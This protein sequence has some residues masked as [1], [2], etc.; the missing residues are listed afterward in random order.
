MTLINQSLEQRKLDEL[1]F[2]EKAKDAAGLFLNFCEL[3]SVSPDYPYLGGDKRWADAMHYTR[4]GEIVRAGV[5]ALREMGG[6]AQLRCLAWLMGYASH[7]VADVT[8]H[9]V[10]DK[11]ICTY[12]ENPKLHRICEMHQDVYIF[13]RMRVGNVGE[14]L[15]SGIR[16]CVDKGKSNFSSIDR[17]W[18][19]LLQEVHPVEYSS[20][21]PDIKKWH[22]CFSFVIDAID[23]GDRLPGIFQHMLS[24]QGA[25]Y[26][27]VVQVKSSYI[28]GLRPPG[29]VLPLHYDNIF[30]QAIINVRKVLLEIS[31]GVFEDKE[32]YATLIEDWNLDTGRVTENSPVAFWE[33]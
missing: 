22:Q 32:G 28:T 31:R 33:V 17:F 2:P 1:G 5:R 6:D 15:K 13:Q 10:L 25:V 3:G 23:E 8:V 29:G 16:T 14:H 30:D 4:T 19:S 18:S 7:V 9:P 27:S 20:N 11:N 12:E 24:E 26:P 21:K